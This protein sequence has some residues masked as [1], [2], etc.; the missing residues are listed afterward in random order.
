MARFV[1]WQI[2]LALKFISESFIQG[3]LSQKPKIHKQMTLTVICQ[4]MQTFVGILCPN[5]RDERESM[6]DV[7]VLKNRKSSE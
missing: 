5:K 6:C 7:F 2:I 3:H 1:V 4:K